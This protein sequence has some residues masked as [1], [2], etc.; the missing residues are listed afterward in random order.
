MKKYFSKENIPVFI[1]FVFVVT[2]F[3]LL[4]YDYLCDKKN[5]VFEN[6]DL[7]ILDNT[8]IRNEDLEKTDDPLLDQKLN[9]D[10]STLK[11]NYQYIGKLEIPKISLVKG[12]VSKDSRYNNISR[13]VTVLNEADYPDVDY[14]NFILVAHSGDAYISFFRNLYKLGINDVAYVTYNNVKYTYEIK[15]IYLVEKTGT[16]NI[17]RN[18]NKTTLTLITC[19]QNDDYHQTVYIAE[20]V[21]K[22]GV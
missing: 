12:F 14:G 5:K 2:G 17:R 3:I 6:M 10:E 9:D 20:L 19:T 13:N 18:Y 15:D 8:E 21:D 1:G 7:A 16:V 22:K 4:S 11:N